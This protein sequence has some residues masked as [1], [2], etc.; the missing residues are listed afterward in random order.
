MNTP[1][2][3]ILV[4]TAVVSLAGC[5]DTEAAK[6]KEREDAEAKARAEAARKEMERLPET[7]RPRYNKKL[8]PSAQ[9]PSEAERK[10]D[11]QKK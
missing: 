7:F 9:P 2:Q 4:L 6:R 10:T 8:E 5:T 3:I 11:A 1:R